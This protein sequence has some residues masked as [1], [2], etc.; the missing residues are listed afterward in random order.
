[1]CLQHR[2]LHGEYRVL[3]LD[4]AD[5]DNDGDLDVVLGNVSIGPGIVPDDQAVTWTSSGVIA[6]ILRNMTR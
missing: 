6:V 1:M 3:H 4:V 5:V 2:I